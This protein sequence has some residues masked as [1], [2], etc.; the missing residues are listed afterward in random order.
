MRALADGMRRPI[1]D[2]QRMTTNF[3]AKQPIGEHAPSHVGGFRFTSDETGQRH[4]ENFTHAHHPRWRIPQKRPATTGFGHP[5]CSYSSQSVDHS[6]NVLNE[7]TP[8]NISH[9]IDNPDPGRG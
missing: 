9:R 6:S 5:V 4:P 3:S 1:A 7:M 2:A 8:D